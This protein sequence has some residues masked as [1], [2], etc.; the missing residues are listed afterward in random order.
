MA[1]FLE[2]HGS[3]CLLGIP[4]WSSMLN[5]SAYK[6]L[7]LTW[8][9]EPDLLRLAEGLEE[10]CQEGTLEYW[11][12]HKSLEAAE[13]QD[14]SAETWARI[15][16]ASEDLV[17]SVSKGKSRVFK[18]VSANVTS[19]RPEVRQ[20]MVSQQFDVALI[21]EHHLSEKA[22]QAESV[23]LSKAG[24]HLHGRHAPVRKREIGG[25]MVCVRSHLQARHIHTFQD[26][27][28][29]C[30]FVAIAVRVTGFDLALFSL[31]L[32]TGSN[33]EG[34]VNTSVL[35]NLHAVIA[36]LQC[37]WCVVGD[38]NLDASDVLATRL[39]DML[40]WACLAALFVMIVWV[41]GGG[42]VGGLQTA[43]TFAK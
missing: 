15:A 14:H 6:A 1:P 2:K 34:Q 32:E 36:T 29:G 10:H 25:V 4:S 41:G 40:S 18:F 24:Y 33:F 39:E 43:S 37:P 22:F 3:R 38:W 30:G 17:H 26:P 23:A 27:E 19:W 20:W 11:T 5:L 7:H 35:S 9:Q 28:T 42:V 16:R 8:N 13:I 31:Y 21:Q 12:L